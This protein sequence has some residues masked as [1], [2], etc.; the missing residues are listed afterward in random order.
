MAKIAIV[1]GGVS[2]LSA[3]IYAQLSGHTATICERH[4]IAGGNLTGWQRGEYHIDN[5][6]HWLTGT[7]P[8]TEGYRMWE[9]LGALGA[10]DVYQ[11]PTLYTCEGNGISISLNA[12]LEQTKNDM[13]KITPDD[14]KE[15]MSLIKA[16]EMLQGLVGI[17]G[18][19]HNEKY[20]KSQIAISAP[21]LLKY[22]NLSAK[23]L[24]QRFKSPLL[25]QFICS[26]LGDEFSSLALIAIWAHFCG[27]NGGLPKGGSLAMA[28]RMTD[29]FTSLGGELLLK[30]EAI[31]IEHEKNKALA[32]NLSN[33]EKITAD[34]VVLTADPAVMFRKLTD[35]PMP[36][37][38]KKLYRDPKLHRF[39]SYQC[40]F[41]CD[42]AEL[43]FS[44]DLM[45]E[46]PPKY[47]S[48]LRTESFALREFS[49]EKSFAPEGNQILQTL[50]FC[51]EKRSREFINMRSDKRTYDAE[52]QELA[53]TLKGLIEA[54]L[55]HLK[56]KLTC[57]DVWT[58]ATYQRYVDSE[59]GSFMSF[60]LPKGRLPIRQSNRIK[61]LDNVILA[62]QW[63]QM[64]GGLPIAADGGKKAVETINELEFQRYQAK[65][66]SEKTHRKD[67]P[68]K[69]APQS[70]Q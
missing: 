51:D 24:A 9:T 38:L 60:A 25:K 11:P 14:K 27:E 64:P 10:V 31:G 45:I 21:T 62:T 2:G 48:L 7:N 58:P 56:D 32:I 47:H 44:G 16:V 22:Y 18:E 37:Q 33:G 39:S 61:G 46:I 15:I 36:S 53:A 59:I 67:V 43:G 35:I 54:K 55:P 34:Y 52:K 70:S 49:H 8:N 19:A 4:H 40:A 69:T 26:F 13:L 65:E 63:Q 6:I 20:S 23:D 50:C 28:N 42:A 29:R 30:T 41:S 12:D 57:I 5:C 66:R 3:G 68:A 17:A 1:G